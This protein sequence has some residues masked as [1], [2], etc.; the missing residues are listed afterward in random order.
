MCPDPA[1]FIILSISQKYDYSWEVSHFLPDPTTFIRLSISQKY[2]YS[3]EVSCFLPGSD[4][5]CYTKYIKKVG[6]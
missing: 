3:W 6:L 1:T 2:D 5:I 4:H